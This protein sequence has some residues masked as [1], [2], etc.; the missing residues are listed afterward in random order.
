MPTPRPATDSHA[1]VQ[2]LMDPWQDRT[3][4]AARVQPRY[5]VGLDAASD[6]KRFGWAVAEC[7]DGGAHLVAQGLLGTSGGAWPTPLREALRDPG[8][9]LLAIDAPLGWPRR[10][11]ETLVAHRAGEAVGVAKND[12]FRRATDDVVR[13]VLRKQPLE[14]GADLI[15]RAAMEALAVLGE[16]RRDSGKALPLA[17]SPGAAR[18]AVIEVYP[19]ATLTAHGVARSK[20]KDPGT[21]GARDPMVEAFEPRLAGMRARIGEPSDVFDACLCI[22]CGLDFLDGRCIAPDATQREAAA[23]EGWIWFARP[24][25]GDSQD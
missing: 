8:G 19:G 13:T 11:G 7:D 21:A 23:V 9:A 10:M 15:A 22:V 12:L 20:Y 3:M 14:V 2:W 18:D 24:I 25:R 4:D 6:R 1:A 17:W 5:L 16:L